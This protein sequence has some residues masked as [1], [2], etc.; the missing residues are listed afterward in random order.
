MEMPIGL[1]QIDHVDQNFEIFNVFFMLPT[2]KKNE[3]FRANGFFFSWH[4]N[5]GTRTI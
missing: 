2:V 3:K 4:E 1:P 5:L